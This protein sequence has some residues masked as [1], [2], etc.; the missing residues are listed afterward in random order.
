[1][2]S[3]HINPQRCCSLYEGSCV[4]RL[5]N[6]QVIKLLASTLAYTA[7]CKQLTGNVC[8]WPQLPTSGDLRYFPDPLRSSFP[9]GC[10]WS[11]CKTP[12]IKESECMWLEFMGIV[13]VIEKLSAS[14]SPEWLPIV[15]SRWWQSIVLIA[16]SKSSSSSLSLWIWNTKSFW[17][18]LY[19]FFHLMSA[20]VGFGIRP[21][22]HR[23]TWM[24]FPS[25][26]KLST[27]SGFGLADMTSACLLRETCPSQWKHNMFD[28]IAEHG[29]I[30]LIWGNL[31]LSN[32]F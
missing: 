13:Y 23:E 21:V 26:G 18:S 28:M 29:K 9:S 31:R 11:E 17:A 10:I 25:L 24:P 20:P 4:C 2:L 6:P 27:H 12:E 22:K 14:K 5:W 32:I 15:H 19:F 8:G 7:Q 16:V 1:M 3:H 30:H